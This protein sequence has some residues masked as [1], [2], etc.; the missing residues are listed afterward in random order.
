MDF[1]VWSRWLLS[2]LFTLTLLTCLL[3]WRLANQPGVVVSDSCAA[4][5]RVGIV[6]HALMATGM[7]LMFA[8]AGDPVPR[9]LWIAVFAVFAAGFA[10]SAARTGPL[11]DRTTEHRR[12]LRLQQLMA[13]VGMAFM[14]AAMPANPYLAPTGT[15]D[16]GGPTVAG[17][18]QNP[19]QNLGGHLHAA[20][21]AGTVSIW[22]ASGFAL[23]FLARTCWLARAAIVPQRAMAL[24]GSTMAGSSTK[25][26]ASPRFTA[27]YELL[28]N[29][30]MGVM[31]LSLVG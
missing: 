29:L 10:V 5:G 7:L 22:L 6:T 28:L 16:H 26:V 21:F 13:C 31:M 14:A 19:T 9:P 25:L 23:Y 15:H 8:P 18:T 1:P 2:L 30:G 12:S 4:D 20:G 27:G 3:R 11:V 24:V 17:T